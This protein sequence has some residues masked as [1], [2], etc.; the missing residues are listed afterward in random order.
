MTRPWMLPLASCLI[1]VALWVWLMPV[2]HL[3]VLVT[4]FLG[5]CV[6]GCIHTHWYLHRRNRATR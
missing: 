3:D 4:G 6:N 5:G 1:P 2:P